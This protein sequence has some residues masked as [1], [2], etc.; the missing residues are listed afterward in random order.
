MSPMT[1]LEQTLPLPF[2]T[3]EPPALGWPEDWL[4]NACMPLL[5]A[6]RSLDNLRRNLPEI[7]ADHRLIDDPAALKAALRAATT[8][9]MLNELDEPARAAVGI[10]LDDAVDQA[11]P[12]HEAAVRRAA[13]EQRQAEDA[14]RRRQEQAETDRLAAVQAEKAKYADEL[15]RATEDERRRLIAL[16]DEK[17]RIEAQR[18]A[19]LEAQV[20][21]LR[22]KRQGQPAA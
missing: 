13:E 3:A 4:V 7:L 2:L 6:L 22:R 14:E 9:R 1:D 21:D 8:A 18:L 19:E 17:E 10:L 11:G 15:A 12:I 5:R 16:R 20:E